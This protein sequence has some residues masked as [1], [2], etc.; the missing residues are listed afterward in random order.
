MVIGS[1]QNNIITPN[2]FEV[3]NFYKQFDVVFYSGYTYLG[4]EYP[5]LQSQSGHYYYNGDAATANTSNLPIS[6]DSPWT[7]DF[8]FEC[9]YG[10]SVS[11]ENSAYRTNFGDG[12]Y[13][14]LSK[15]E[16]SLKATFNTSF[17]KRSDSETMC[18]IHFLE[19]SFNKGNKPSGGYTGIYWQ[20]FV[21]YDYR[22][23]FF[24][25][26][27]DHSIQYP[28]VNS[29]STEFYNETSSITD[30]QNL[31]IPFKNT[32]GFFEIGKTYSKHDIAFA[33]GAAY[34][35]N[36]SGW[37]YYTGESAVAT[38]DNS[39]IGAN[40]LW[41]KNNFYFDIND[42]ISIS[43][44]PRFFKQ[45][46]Q[47]GF[48]Q[49]VE[50][51]IN[52]SLLNLKF[53]LKGRTDKESKAIV[54]FLIHKYGRNQFSFTPPF[55]YNKSKVFLCPSWDHKINYKDNNDISVNFIEHPIDYLAKTTEFL[56]LITIDP[57]LAR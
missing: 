12:Y 37:Y 40:S 3:G 29:Y 16:N 57:Y 13:S 56:N 36:T 11:F 5:A 9:E 44:S 18:A 49:R 31:Y 6:E 43:Q 25:E 15:S 50:D 39:P 54:H 33:S 10:S 46:F 52:K 7:Q 28:N 19:D 38:S 47:N 1:G 32:S 45:G 22:K 8:F 26:K 53:E 35:I 23:E 51:G 24:I 48:L 14:Y 17:E 41:T 55:P 21:P 2:S 30:W 27:I 42:G 20:P 4:T 34:N